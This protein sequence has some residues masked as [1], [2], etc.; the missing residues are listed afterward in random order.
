[1]ISG[2]IGIGSI[3]GFASLPLDNHLYHI[4]EDGGWVHRDCD[5][6][7]CKYRSD[8]NVL[9][10]MIPEVFKIES[11]PLVVFGV[12]KYGM[13]HVGNYHA[14]TLAVE[15]EYKG[16]RLMY[17][18]RQVE[19]TTTAVAAGHP[20]G[21][22]KVD[23]KVT[24]SRAGPLVSARVERPEG[25]VLATCVFRPDHF[26]GEMKERSFER[27]GVRIVESMDS[28]KRPD[29]IQVVKLKSRAYGGDL[30]TGEGA[31]FFT[32]AS[33]IDPLHRAPV[34]EVEECSLVIGSTL[35]VG[36]TGEVVD[37]LETN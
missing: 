18:I 1:M 19:T 22:P 5:I 14:A 11:R 29:M 36:P 21:I 33:V 3:G 35:E 10:T 2:T 28:S 8:G 6:L 4:N 24:L 23:G 37:L 7:L 32:G 20:L 12:G 16:Q 13:S 30:W 9:A 17:D 25:I 15:V 31:P 34:L 27:L 26:K